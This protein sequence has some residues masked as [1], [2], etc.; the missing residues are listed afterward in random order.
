MKVVLDTRPGSGYLD[1][2][3]RYHFPTRYLKPAVA[4]LGQWAVLYEPRRE[5]GRAA[6]VAAARIADVT[7]DPELP[8]HH[9]ARL[10]ERLPFDE[11]VP[12]RGPAGYREA[13]L[14][15]VEQPSAVGRAL[16]GKSIRPLSDADFA[17]IV[18]AGLS[19][20]LAPANRRRL[21][22]HDVTDSAVAELLD[23]PTIAP[24]LER[25]L[26]SRTVRDAAFRRAV[27]N[28]Y[29]DTCAATRLRMINGGGRAEAQAC[30]IVPV[31]DGGPDVVQNGIA[32]SATIH[33][34]FDRHLV[35]IGEDWRLLVS[36]NRVPAELR[37]LMAGHGS[38]IRL[39]TDASLWPNPRFIADH[40]DRFASMA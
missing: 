34:L 16:Q 13:P 19:E 33:W 39:P 7:P 14:R 10:T 27:L 26:A 37:G 20:T 29:D 24:R 28:A 5:G 31:S 32:L 3:D 9:F 30:H 22:L 8:G 38:A 23:G 1:S 18:G 40:R 35:S 15:A 36:H 11:A 25:V 6:Y 17:E 2:E 12:L 21:Y 4:A